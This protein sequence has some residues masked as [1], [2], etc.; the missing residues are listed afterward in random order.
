MVMNI[1]TCTHNDQMRDTCTCTRSLNKQC[2]RAATT[3]NSSARQPNITLHLPCHPRQ[4]GMFDQ[5]H[6]NYQSQDA[7]THTLSDMKSY[8]QYYG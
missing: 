2:T 7:N 4:C 3:S 5:Q 6:M 8:T 1:N